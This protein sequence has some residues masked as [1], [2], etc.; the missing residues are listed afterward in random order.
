MAVTNYG[1]HIP[2]AVARKRI[3]LPQLLRELNNRYKGA[4]LKYAQLYRDA[5]NGVLPIHQG[6]NSRYSADEADIPRIAE[7][8]GLLG[9]EQI[10][11]AA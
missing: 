3:P 5:L 6:P 8:L 4:N 9:P 10:P 7:L 1:T 11:T 2:L